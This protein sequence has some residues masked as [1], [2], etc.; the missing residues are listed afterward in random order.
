MHAALIPAFFLG[1]PGTATSAVILGGMTIVGLE[2]GPLVYVQHADLVLAVFEALVVGSIFVFVVGLFVTTVWAN[3]IGKIE[4]SLLAIGILVLV[5]MG[6]YAATSTLFG[7]Y[8]AFVAGAAGYVLKKR[9][10][11]LPALVV[12]FVIGK[13]LEANLG[14][15]LLIS[16]G[17]VW[18]LLNHPFVLVMVSVG[19]AVAGYTVWS[20]RHPLVT[21][22]N[23]PPQQNHPSS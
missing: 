10:F 13:P 1:L 11:S 21:T 7:V 22:P 20:G 23:E 15:A 2:P 8:V 18:E 3:L 12:G 16:H 5:T 9:D 6:S 19:L 14:R 17:S 4:P